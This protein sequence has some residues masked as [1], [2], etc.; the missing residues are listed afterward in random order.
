MAPESWFHI[1]RCSRTNSGV[2][3]KMALLDLLLTAGSHVLKCNRF[4]DG[5]PLEFCVC[6]LCRRIDPDKQNAHSTWSL[7]LLRER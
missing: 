6:C 1:R 5:D 2:K 4:G 7:S 3:N